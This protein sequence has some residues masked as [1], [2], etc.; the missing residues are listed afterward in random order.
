MAACASIEQ[1]LLCKLV[2]SMPRRCL[3]VIKQKGGLT[4]Y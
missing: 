3:A 2:E 1:E 4:K